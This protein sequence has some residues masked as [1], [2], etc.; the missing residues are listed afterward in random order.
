MPPNSEQTVAQ[1]RAPRRPSWPALA[2]SAAFGLLY[3]YYEWDA[4]RSLMELPALYEALG[5]PRDE[6]PWALLVIGVLLPALCYGVAFALG[7]A[8]SLARRAAYFAL[9]LGVVACLSLDI[10]AL[11]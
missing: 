6:V 9:G 1:T 5:L 11:G 10:I 2:V 8:S 4:L 7:R 3:A